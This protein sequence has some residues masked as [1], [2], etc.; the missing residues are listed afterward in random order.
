MQVVEAPAAAQ[1][2]A[3]HQGV[4]RSHRTSALRATVQN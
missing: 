4:Q 3:Q 2:L 1:Q